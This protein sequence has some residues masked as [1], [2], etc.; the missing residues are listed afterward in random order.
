MSSDPFLKVQRELHEAEKVIADLVAEW[1]ES[2]DGG[3]H[4]KIMTA[5]ANALRWL[6]M[7]GSV[8]LD[9]DDGRVVVGRWAKGHPNER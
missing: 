9:V 3:L 6:A 7:K 4:S 8:V 2:S 5:N 1:C